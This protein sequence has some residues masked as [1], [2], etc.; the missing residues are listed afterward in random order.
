MSGLA[1]IVDSSIDLEYRLAV[2]LRSLEHQG[3]NERGFWVSSFVETRLG[4]AHCGKS[5]GELEEDVRQPYVDEETQLVVTVVGDIYN[6]RELRRRLQVHYTFVTDSSVEVVSKAYHRW[7]EECLV[8]LNGVF[9]LVIYDRVKDV[10]LL[11][12]DRFGVK[13]LYYSTHQGK[14]YFA[15]EVRSLFAAGVPRRMSVEQWAGYMLYSSYGAPYATF[16]EGVYQL[17]AGCL[18]RYNGYSL[19]DKC[20]YNLQDEIWELLAGYKAMEL[21][22]MFAAEVVHSIARSMSDVTICG[23]RVTGRIESQL[24]YM[25]AAQGQQSWKIRTFTGDIDYIGQQPLASPIWVTADDAVKELEQMQYWLEEPFDGSESVVR[26]AMFRQ[27]RHN[28]VEVAFS[29]MGLDVLW[30]DVWDSTEQIYNYIVHHDIFSRDIV[31]WAT[32]PVYECVFGRDT[33]KMRYLDLYYERIPHILRFFDR[34]A[35]EAGLCVRMPFLDGHMVALS[36]VL[37]A[38][39]RNSRS[40]IFKDYVEQNYHAPV[41]SIKTMSLMPMWCDGGLK[42]WVC[43]NLAVLRSGRLREWFNPEQLQ[44]LCDDF[45]NNRKVD[46]VLLWKCISLQQLSSGR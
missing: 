30:Q 3:G 44:S 11:A 22:E 41:E 13:P 33:D 12:R 42:E 32:R 1:G 17:P 38:I 20:W 2:M 24:L 16:W 23:L 5:V 21:S 29:G 28:G 18:M 4:L 27:A 46:I 19:S 7:G 26:M 14:L 10:L 43:D 37:P 8:Q 40:N 15:S 39:L 31:G 34:S 36:F 9:A 45:Y 35:S 25:I 6:Y